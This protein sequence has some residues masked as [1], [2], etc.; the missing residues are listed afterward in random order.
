MREQLRLLQILINYWDPDIEAFNLDGYP[1][2]IE[3]DGIYYIT[4][5]S[6]QGEIINLRAHGVGRGMNIDDYIDSYYL[7]DIENM[8]IQVPIWVIQSLSMM[9]I[10]LVLT[11]IS[12]STLLH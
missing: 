7:P 2:K 9:I 1:L 4:R 8:G 12:S 6:H 10:I 3:V 11:R 5:L